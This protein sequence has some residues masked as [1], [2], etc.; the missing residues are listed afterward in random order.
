MRAG[1]CQPARGAAR[2]L[3]VRLARTR[4]PT[5]RP[6]RLPPCPGQ[7]LDSRWAGGTAGRERRRLPPPLHTPRN[8]R[9]PTQ[10]RRDASLLHTPAQHTR[11]QAA[12]IPCL[13]AS[14][15]VPG[16][17]R[18]NQLLDRIQGQGWQGAHPKC[19]SMS[20]PPPEGFFSLWRST[21]MPSAASN[22]AASLPALTRGGENATTMCGGPVGAACLRPAGSS[23]QT[24]PPCPALPCPF[25]PRTL[26]PCPLGPRTLPPCP[27]PPC[28]LLPLTNVENDVEK[29]ECRKEE[30][31]E[32]RAHRLGRTAAGL[33]SCCT[34]PAARQTRRGTRPGCPP[35]ADAAAAGRALQGGRPGAAG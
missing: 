12:N 19:R 25:P 7:P 33:Q 29:N 10:W 14:G 26:P 24:P 23:R 32:E 16:W 21:G 20:P 3:G 5:R 17:G 15:Q 9:K 13:A 28:P 4:Q 8:A 2:R 11:E 27:F 35:R 22:A 31:Q 1:A 18:F 30:D 34:A 6:R